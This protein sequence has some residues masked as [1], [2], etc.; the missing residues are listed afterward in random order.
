MIR[1]IHFGGVHS[2]QVHI[3][4]EISL[5]VMLPVVIPEGPNCE[6][7]G[8]QVKLGIAV[9]IRLTS[10]KIVLFNI[11]NSRMGPLILQYH[12]QY[13]HLILQS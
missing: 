4:P 5:A 6:I 12:R 9:T 2:R 7:F 3:R 1:Y 8:H 13:D 10:P 11:V